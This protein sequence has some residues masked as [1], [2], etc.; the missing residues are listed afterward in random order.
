MLVQVA[1]VLLVVYFVLFAVIPGLLHNITRH[2][3]KDSD[4]ERQKFARKIRRRA[5]VS[6]VVLF[7]LSFPS[8]V[9]E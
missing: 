7:L 3:F 4:P 5:I 2:S 8:I 6:G 9:L 1:A